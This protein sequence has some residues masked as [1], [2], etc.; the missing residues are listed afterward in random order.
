MQFLVCKKV[1][2]S[3]CFRS[4]N[5]EQ[6]IVAVPQIVEDYQKN[7]KGVDLLDQMVGYYMPHH[8]SRKWW[9]RIFHHLQMTTAF[10]AYVLAKDCN[11]HIVRR[12]WPQF[13]VTTF[14]L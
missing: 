8:R 10:N 2:F 13:K 1:F 4:G 9:R 5:P 7:M 3:I 6:R 12:E 14:S 11:P